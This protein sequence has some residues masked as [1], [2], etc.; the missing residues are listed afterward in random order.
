LLLGKELCMLTGY[1]RMRVA[2]LTVAL[3]AVPAC[4]SMMDPVSEVQGTVLW[5]K[6]PL[7]N[8]QIQFYPDTDQG[9]SGPRSTAVT[10]DQGHYTLSFDDDQPGAVVGH[11]KV[12]MFEMDEDLDRDR[13]AADRHA[14]PKGTSSRPAGLPSLPANYKRVATTPLKREVKPGTQTI[15]FNL[16]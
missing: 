8:V 1:G 11:H 15:D 16:P 12:L 4:G 3:L 10:D 13:R 7:K 14:R 2:F 5:H 9:T 6:K